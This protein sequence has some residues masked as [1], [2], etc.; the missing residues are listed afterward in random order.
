MSQDGGF[1][2][3]PEIRSLYANNSWAI[4]LRDHD[5]Y[6][7]H[8]SYGHPYYLAVNTHASRS[9]N[10]RRYF[11]I[12]SLWESVDTFTASYESAIASYMKNK[13]I[14]P[15]EG[16]LLLATASEAE[17][18]KIESEIGKASEDSNFRLLS[19]KNGWRPSKTEFGRD[20]ARYDESTFASEIQ[21]FINK[22]LKNIETAAKKKYVNYHR[23]GA[24]NK[25][26]VD[27]DR[28]AGY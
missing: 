16:M 4:G 7:L 26:D 13:N 20:G 9:I 11:M 14:T 5:M 3:W 21:D 6:H 28:V 10:D 2:S 17:L 8:Y 12:S 18:T 22:A 27:E 24:G 19:Y 15:Q 25:S 1:L 23:L